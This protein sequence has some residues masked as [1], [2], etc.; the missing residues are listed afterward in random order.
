MRRK[1]HN[2]IFVDVAHKVKCNWGFLKLPFL[3]LLT[4]FVFTNY[5]LSFRYENN[6]FDFL[7]LIMYDRDKCTGKKR[8]LVGKTDS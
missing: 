8:Q 1:F 7:N 6:P 2:L 3:K 4:P 5:H